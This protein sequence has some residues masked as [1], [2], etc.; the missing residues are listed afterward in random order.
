MDDIAVDSSRGP[1]ADGRI[2][3]DVVAPGTAITGGRSGLDS[4]SGNIG[5]AHRWSSGSSHSA[6]QISGVAAVFTNWWYDNNFGDW[7]S[8]SLVKAALINSS[9]DLNG[10]GS[11]AAIPNGIEGYVR[12]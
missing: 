3:P 2:K 10:N 7:P 6:A 11:S 5:T 9:R 1:A 12:I 4:L 8:P